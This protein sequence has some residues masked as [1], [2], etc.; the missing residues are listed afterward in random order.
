[1]MVNQHPMEGSQKSLAFSEH[2]PCAT[3]M[4]GMLPPLSLVPTSQQPRVMDAIIPVGQ[5]SQCSSERCATFQGCRVNGGAGSN[6]RLCAPETVFS[7]PKDGLTGGLMVCHGHLQ[8]SELGHQRRLAHT[9]LPRHEDLV[10]GRVNGHS[11][12]QHWSFKQPWGKKGA[13][14]GQVV[15]PSALPHQTPGGTTSSLRAF[16]APTT[17]GSLYSFPRPGTQAA[18]LGKLC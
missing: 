15:P 17:R 3:S 18:F 5:R 12:G 16:S 2:V 10:A 9:A 6:P 1:M 8:A 14:W 7:P 13:M 4:L 11:W